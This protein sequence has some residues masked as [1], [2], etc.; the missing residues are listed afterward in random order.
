MSTASPTPIRLFFALDARAQA[1]PL[2]AIQRQW[3][4][5]IAHT[6]AHGQG[7]PQPAAQPSPVSA[8][9]LHLTL[10]FLG[11]QPMS[12]IPLLSQQAE[13][14]LDAQATAPF[15]IQL[16]HLGLFAKAKVAWMAPSQPPEPLL[17]LE[18]ELRAALAA[19]GIGVEDR[20]YRP[21][22]TLL[23]KATRLLAG[24]V[25]PITLQ[26]TALHLYES[27]STPDGVRYI[28][29]A[30]W[31]FAPPVFSKRPVIDE[32]GPSAAG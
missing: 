12:Q 4:Q 20:P 22:V 3:L 1:E 27:R 18:A 19:V 31:D 17:R 32:S 13:R 7:N 23:R 15:A 6:A 2:L 8:E 29:L 25:T 30:S 9:N 11:N 16:D 10:L 28:Q 24:T 21:H 14:V 26:A 5:E